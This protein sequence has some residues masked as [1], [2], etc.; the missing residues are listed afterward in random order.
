MTALAAC[1]LLAWA[2][3][4][5]RLARRGRCQAATRTADLRRRGR[6]PPRRGLRRRHRPRRFRPG[7]RFLRPAV[8]DGGA[9]A[10]HGAAWKLSEDERDRDHRDGQAAGRRR[11]STRGRCLS[12]DAAG[13]PIAAE[14]R[15]RALAGA[16]PPSMGEATIH[17]RQQWEPHDGERLYGLGQH[18]QG[19][20]DIKGTDLDLHQDNTEIFIPFLVSSRGYGILWDNTS[21]TRFGGSA[22]RPLGEIPETAGGAADGDADARRFAARRLP[23]GATV[24][25][26]GDVAVAPATGDYL[27]AHSRAIELTVGRAVIDTGARLAPGEDIAHSPATRAGVPLHLRWKADIGVKI[28]P[29]RRHAAASPTRRPRSGRRSATASTTTSSTGPALDRRHRRLPPASPAQAPMLPRWAFGF[30]QSPRALPNRRRRAWTC[31]TGSARASIPIDNDRPGLAVLARRRLGLARV[32]SR[33]ASPIPKAGSRASTT[34]ARAPDDLGVA[35][36]LSRHGR[37][38]R[39]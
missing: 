24:D 32:R 27:L 6:A 9:E 30:W 7:R 38:S 36:V 2:S 25:W 1:G 3:R 26:T 33:S 21:L 8:A 13:R 18:Q 31:S 34:E 37:T 22:S 35:E 19:L 5:G 10:M 11:S 23:A 20:L 28:A 16:A 29:L 12:R 4:L 39:R 17:V 14:R 15:G